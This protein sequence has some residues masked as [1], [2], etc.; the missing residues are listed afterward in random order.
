MQVGSK[1]GTYYI[2]KALRPA[3]PGQSGPERDDPDATPT[4]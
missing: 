3:G 1:R 4:G 2:L